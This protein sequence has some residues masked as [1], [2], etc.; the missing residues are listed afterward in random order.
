MNLL[1]K[2][3]KL[4]VYQGVNVSKD[5]YL[6]INCSVEH[7]EFARLCAKYAYEKQ[8]KYVYINYT[9]DKLS[10]M[11]YQN[12]KT[13]FLKEVAD[14]EI[15]RREYQIN[16]KC[17]YLHIISEIPG[18]LKDIDSSKLQ[19]VQLELM[20][21]LEPFKY[22]TMNNVGQWSIVAMPNNSWAAKVFPNLNEKEAYDK[23]MDAILDSVMVSDTSDPIK[24]WDI[25]NNNIISR[26]DKM[27]KHHFKA[28]NLKMIRVQI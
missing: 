18:L 9:D 23:L 21:K 6:V 12:V 27:N 13:E 15:A 26:R 25:H 8:A 2:Y 11:H 22:Y 10:L 4:A 19:E 14:W 28:L 5:Q 3:A 1:E 20:S 16:Q 17:C 7:Y 24:E